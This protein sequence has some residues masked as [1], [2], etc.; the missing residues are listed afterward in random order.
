MDY[1]DHSKEKA[2]PVTPDGVTLMGG[3]GKDY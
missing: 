1:F 3:G 2:I